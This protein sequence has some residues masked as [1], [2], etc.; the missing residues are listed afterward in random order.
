MARAW[1][2]LSVVRRSLIGSSSC[3]SA[4]DLNAIKNNTTIY[5]P[6]IAEEGD[7]A[8]ATR[9]THGDIVAYKEEASSREN[10]AAI[11]I[12]AHFRGH[13]VDTCSSS[14]VWDSFCVVDDTMLSSGSREQ[15]RRAFRALKSLR[16][17]RSS[18]TLS[19][20]FFLLVSPSFLSLLNS[21]SLFRLEVH[22]PRRWEAL[23]RSSRGITTYYTDLVLLGQES[24]TGTMHQ[25]LEIHL[26]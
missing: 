8:S 15:A 24:V 17:N 19:P 6:M 2:W 14:L 22:F 9:I 12:Q 5:N 26:T 4:A 7:R 16:T 10:S 23:Y 1:R 20:L 18:S 25:I 11:T 13:L 3:T 21:S